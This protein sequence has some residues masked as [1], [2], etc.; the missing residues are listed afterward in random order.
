LNTRREMLG[1]K[2]LDKDSRGTVYLL[3]YWIQL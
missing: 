3:A 2:R 1:G